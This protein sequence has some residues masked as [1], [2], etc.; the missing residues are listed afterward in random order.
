[1][2]SSVGLRP[3]VAENARYN[4]TV[5]LHASSCEPRVTS[6]RPRSTPKAVRGQRGKVRSQLVQKQAPRPSMS[7][8]Q[9][10]AVSSSMRCGHA[11]RLLVIRRGSWRRAPDEVPCVL[12]PRLTKADVGACA[13]NL[14]S[15]HWQHTQQEAGYAPL[16]LLRPPRLRTPQDPPHDDEHSQERLRAVSIRCCGAGHHMLKAPHMSCAVLH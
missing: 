10:T 9:Y 11:N 15:M 13:N 5:C 14:G 4:N 2:L 12:G 1:M 16:P 7:P 6:M 3:G 8:P